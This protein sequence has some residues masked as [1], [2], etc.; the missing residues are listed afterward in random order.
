[1]KMDKIVIRGKEEFIAEP[2]DIPADFLT[3]KAAYSTGGRFRS[4]ADKH[5]VVL[6]PSDIIELVFEDDTTWYC[7]PDTLEEVFPTTSL[8]TRDTDGSTE[9]PQSITSPYTERGLAGEAFLRLFRVFTKKPIERGIRELAIDLE[10]KQL[11][12][13]SGLF[14]VR[15]DF[16]L[17]TFA[18]DTSTKPYLLLIHGTASSTKGSFASMTTM[19][20]WPGLRALYGERIIAFQ[21]ETLSKSPL[22]NAYELAKALPDNAVVHLITHSRGGIVGDIL[23]RYAVDDENNR[24]FS[25]DER[26]YLKKTGRTADLDQIAALDQL[27][28]IKRIR[29]N[30]FVRVACPAGGTILASGRLDR[31]FNV[32]INLIGIG[33][34]LVVNPAFLALKSLLA[35]VINSKNE[36][37]VLPGLEAMNPD[38]PFIKILNSP[39]SAVRI[40]TPL[41]IISGNCKS[42]PS[43][44]ALLIIASKIFYLNDN[45]LV[46]NTRSMYQ[47]SR[48]EHPVKYYFDEGSDV[49]HFSYFINSRTGEAMLNALKGFPGDALPGFSTVDQQLQYADRQALLKLDG[50]QVFTNT[51]TGTRPIVLLLPGIM[52]SNLQH[53]DELV[54]IN[55]PRFIIG[56]LKRLAITSK[57]I[58]A[59][60]IVKSSYYQLVRNLS[61]DYDV[62]TFPYDWRRPL[63]DTTEL[64]K[65][66]IEELLTYHQPIKII[67]H[68]MGGV[69]MRDFMVLQRPTWQR[70]NQSAQFR[71]LFLGSPLGGSYRIPY[72]LF[73]RDAM[74]DKLARIDIFHTRRELLTIFSRFP[75]LLSLLPLSEDTAHDFSDTA[76]WEKMRTAAG[77]PDWPLPAAGDLKAFQEHRTA[78]TRELQESDYARAVYI[79]GQDTATPCGYRIDETAKGP[80]L[81]FLSTAEG[82]QSVTWDSGIPKRMIADK[83][84]YYARVSHGSLANDPSLFNPIRDIL[85]NGTTAMLNRNRPVVRAEQKVFR[86][87]ELNDFDISPMGLEHTLLGLKEPVPESEKIPPVEVM[88]C[89]GD[90]RYSRYPVIAGHFMND[91]ILYAE[92]AIDKN[93]RG[94]LSDR[95]ALGI[96]PGAVGSSEVLIPNSGPFPGAVIVGLGVQGSLTAFQL[97][98]TVAQAAARYILDVNRKGL[99][100]GLEK[101]GI[102]SLIIGCGFGGLTVD[103]S[104]RAILQGIQ[105]ANEKIRKAGLPDLRLI[106]MVEFVEQY[107]DRA[108]SCF[109]SVTRIEHEESR[110]LTISTAGRKIISLLGSRKRLPSDATEEWWNRI[111]VCLETPLADESIISK[112]PSP[113][114]VPIPVSRPVNPSFRTLSF[115]A[116]TGGAREESRN[117]H[118]SSPVLEELISEISSENRWTPALARTIFELLIPNDFKDQLK[119]HGKINWI[120]DKH[121]AAYPW[122]LLQEGGTDSKPLCIN[123]GMI[124]QLK[125]EDY[126]LKI[127]SVS[128]DTALVI[129]DPELKGFLQQLPGAKEEGETV[130]RMLTDN[131]F[132]TST[133]IQGRAPAIIE[134]LFKDEYKIIHLA[135]HG[136]FN[137]HSPDNSGMV[138]GDNIFLSTNEICQMSSV[139]E[140][141]FV[142]CCYLGKTDGVAEAYFR[143]RYRL[144]ANIGTQLIENGVKAVVVAGW[145]V[146]DSAALEFTRAFYQHMLNGMLLGDAVHKARKQVYEKYKNSNNTWGAYQCY[147]DPFYRFTRLRKSS[148]SYLYSFDIQDQAEIE[149]YNLRNTIETGNYNHEDL[150]LQ[151]EAISAA[152]DQNN[153]RTAGITEKE[154]LIYAD[155]YEYEKA[156]SRFETL[157]KMENA[158]FDV[159]TLERYCNI[160]A[161]NFVLEFLKH[162]SGSNTYLS[163]MNSVL[164][165]LETLLNVSPTGERHM[166]L[167]STLKRKAVFISTPDKKMNVL[168]E[169]AYNYMKAYTIND[170]FYAL[171][172]WYQLE[173]LLV[174]TGNRQWSEEVTLK[175]ESYKLPSAAKVAEKLKEA[176]E[177]DVPAMQNYWEMGRKANIRLCMLVSDAIDKDPQNCDAV[178]DDYRVTWNRAGSRGKKFSE[179]E[180]IELLIDAL[181]TSRK[182]NAV[183][184]RKLLEGLKD[185]LLKLI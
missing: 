119:R 25:A 62:I 60:S 28:T 185:D 50:G 123:S 143:N 38:S 152:V 30:S 135:G 107:E 15:E 51:I 85:I 133:I 79:A 141:V 78:I 33:T 165:E 26:A 2:A 76:L 77:D 162:R 81:V 158:S 67:A 10:K 176:L 110:S 113:S 126:R 61:A 112:A 164:K 147:G 27:F 63:T 17:T 49:D 5:T 104:I 140:L 105:N 36:V 72:V 42:K 68:S 102:S 166:L 31:F 32:F 21:H 24:G 178:L 29:I 35:A 129:G 150:L 82:D 39:A 122:E 34:G 116:S 95:R 88:V 86:T 90:L 111:T 146:E 115:S 94:A 54:W 47:G 43:L 57:D 20:L 53:K 137:A 145:A 161:K 160:R 180:H 22:Q 120:L 80:E 108:L 87:P 173:A 168:K 91:G 101:M 23:N 1:M 74:V 171:L 136:I 11:E 75:G 128:T 44:K 97:T 114:A 100:P 19:P 71:L 98:Q 16:T 56:D 181:S 156:I 83:T 177:K 151:L 93:L 84:V 179:I 127:N 118:S 12:Q 40:D 45:D 153:L 131:G 124:R 148:G 92:K 64:L 106:E 155:I 9:L 46:V 138:I 169:A 58:T 172:N 66:K 167:G 121:T 174:L 59:T 99:A 65:A 132:T 18:K 175:N 142:N 130:S 170:N 3:L 157:L 125:T 182:R 52:G 139:P 55:Y 7:S 109:Y 149:L 70:L 159:A 89:N 163:Q 117:L 37:D 183:K 144:A 4:S 73:G 103:S 6:E 8:P 69:L 134:A 14:L 48:R 96:Y 184:L 41:Y 13:Q 154:A